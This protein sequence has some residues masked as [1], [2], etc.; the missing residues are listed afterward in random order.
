MHGILNHA[1]PKCPQFLCCN[2][3]VLQQMSSCENSKLQCHSSIMRD[4]CP[5]AEAAD[6]CGIKS[7]FK[8]D[9]VQCC[10]S[11]RAAVRISSTSRS[12]S[13]AAKRCC[14][15]CSKPTAASPTSPTT[16]SAP[17]SAAAATTTVACHVCQARVDTL[18]GLC[19]DREKVARLF[20]ICKTC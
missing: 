19:K 13:A 11:L 1:R 5:V 15:G 2:Q 20:C 3:K 4:R 9:A 17:A 14:V 12:P 16:S 8:V 7:R 10:L 18:L 6:L